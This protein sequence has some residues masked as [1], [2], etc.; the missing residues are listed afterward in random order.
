MLFLS[1]TWQ[2]TNLSCRLVKKILEWNLPCGLAVLSFVL[3]MM[4]QKF[5]VLLLHLRH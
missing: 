2:K 1:V 3:F 5:N 4:L